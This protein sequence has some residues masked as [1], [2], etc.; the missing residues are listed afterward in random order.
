MKLNTIL[1]IDDEESL[2]HML[3][4]LLKKEGY[5]VASIGSAEEGL[6]ALEATP[7]DLVLCDVRMKGWMVSSFFAK[8]A[9]APMCPP[10]S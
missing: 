3:S 10:W 5:E 4:I 9:T 7:Y 2:R 8:S 1:I 6:K